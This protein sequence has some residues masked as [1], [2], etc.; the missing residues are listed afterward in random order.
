MLIFGYHFLLALRHPTIA[1]ISIKLTI[2]KIV[3]KIDRNSQ[4]LS[5]SDGNNQVRTSTEQRPVK[6]S[7]QW[8]NFVVKEVREDDTHQ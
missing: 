1:I 3:T 2:Q 8:P 4:N 6:K 5:E 7:S